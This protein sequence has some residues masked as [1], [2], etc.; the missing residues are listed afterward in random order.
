MIEVTYDELSELYH[1]G[2]KGQ[3]WGVRRTDAQLGHRTGPTTMQKLGASIRKAGTTSYKVS[4]RAGSSIMNKAKAKMA[5]RQEAK[6]NAINAKKP[7][8]SM[9]DQE[10]K[11]HIERMKLEEQYQQYLSKT[12]RDKGGIGSAVKDALAKAGKKT[13]DA[14]TE[15]YLGTT[16]NNI[17]GAEVV[18]GVGGGKKDDG[19]KDNNGGN[20][21][22]NNGNNNGGGKGGGGN[23]SPTA[24]NISGMDK[25][26]AREAIKQQGKSQAMILKQQGKNDRALAKAQAKADRG[27]AKTTGKN[28]RSMYKTEHSEGRKDTRT[29]NS[30]NRKNNRTN[31]QI[32]RDAQREKDRR[33]RATHDITPHAKDAVNA[34]LDGLTQEEYNRRR[35]GY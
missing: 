27:M 28:E 25:Y 30:E 9:S 34:W 3:K 11:Q 18:K 4:K 5:A 15:Y 19:T 17:L 22:G 20:N 23:G 21:G 13:L 6:K 35:R 1:H 7:L 29:T 31:W 12:G 26:T 33:E 8:S 32:G 14:V 10:I 2:V 24:L 16:V